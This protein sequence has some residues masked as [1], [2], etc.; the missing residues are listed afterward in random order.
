MIADDV[1][2][3]RRGIESDEIVPYFQPLTEL[4]TGQLIGF[5]VLARWKHPLRGMVPPDEFIRMAEDAGCI[6]AL[7]EKVLS[8]AFRAMR[9]LPE[10]LRLSVNVS[11]IQLRN[12]TLRRQVSLASEETGFSL[13]R[14]TV[15]ITEC[16]S[17]STTSG[18]G[19]RVCGTCMLCRSMRSRSTGALFRPC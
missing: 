10:Y 16:E 15:E 14:L 5:E 3:L 18:Q 7:M 1:V 2:D 11:A 4:R 9:P 17:Q 19:T 13:E 12:R 8:Q 6:G